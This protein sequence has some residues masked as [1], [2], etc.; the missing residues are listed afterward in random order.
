[1]GNVSRTW[2]YSRHRSDTRPKTPRPGP[3][4]TPSDADS[5]RWL[6]RNLSPI[7]GAEHVTAVAPLHS[8]AKIIAEQPSTDV[9]APPQA[10]GWNGHLIGPLVLIA[11]H[12]RSLNRRPPAASLPVTQN[13]HVRG[14]RGRPSPVVAEKEQRRNN[15]ARCPV[16]DLERLRALKREMGRECIAIV[17]ETLGIAAQTLSMRKGGPGSR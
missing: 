10:I 16:E 8:G 13:Q 3:K 17:E 15:R 1:M 5:K 7:S 4:R 11:G 2:T 12:P 6:S 9:G 14:A